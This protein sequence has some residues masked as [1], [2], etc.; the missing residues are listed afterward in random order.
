[1]FVWKYVCLV[2]SRIASLA[3]ALTC[4]FRFWVI[5][6]LHIIKYVRAGQK[7][8][9]N[10][11]ERYVWT[12]DGS[13]GMQIGLLFVVQY[14]YAPDGNYY[15][16]TL[17]GLRPSHPHGAWVRFPQ[18]LEIQIIRSSRSSYSFI[19]ENRVQSYGIY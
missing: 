9:K 12:Q 17:C 7:R 10:I 1:M 8:R 18:K 16:F 4:Q 14:S 19:A 3:S 15:Y 11:A 2:R 13:N 6:C 5:L